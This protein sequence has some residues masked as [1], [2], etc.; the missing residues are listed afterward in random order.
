MKVKY[1]KKSDFVVLFIKLLIPFSIYVYLLYLINGF[2]TG[3]Q[4]DTALY[5]EALRFLINITAII[6]AFLFT[7]PK[8]TDIKEFPINK[9]YLMLP[10][11]SYMILNIVFYNLLFG[12]IIPLSS[13][14]FYI[15]N[16]TFIIALSFLVLYL[17]AFIHSE[18][19]EIINY[20]YLLSMFVVLFRNGNIEKY[21]DSI[22]RLV[23]NS[24]TEKD[25]YRFQQ[26]VDKLFLICGRIIES[27]RTLGF[28]KTRSLTKVLFQNFYYIAAETI[29]AGLSRSTIYLIENMTSIVTSC[30]H[31]EL[32]LEYS[33]FIKTFKKIAF[34][35]MKAEMIRI[36]ENTVDIISNFGREAV[37]R[38]LISSPIIEAIVSLQDIGI[39][40]ATMKYENLSIEILSRLQLIAIEARTLN[41]IAYHSALS[42]IWI[43]NSNMY[44]NTNDILE[45]QKVNTNRIKK[46]FNNDYLQAYNSA[47]KELDDSSSTGKTILRD[48][49]SK[50]NE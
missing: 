7:I 20:Y 6:T 15:S 13:I 4:G 48:F 47:L 46:D 21:I 50:L 32:N 3:A 18:V 11:L 43:V 23:N 33:F 39:Q 45:W 12:N 42:A 17:Y 31:L 24:V 2:Y 25:D 44:Y 41:S 37:K 38:Q 40:S 16:L 5:R 35:T 26:G 1:F 8:V 29:H 14:T 19:I 28:K 34:L 10:F 22:R 36:T 49:M 27:E 9:R 30:I